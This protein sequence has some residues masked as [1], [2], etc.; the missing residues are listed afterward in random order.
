VSYS[1]F[2]KGES[3]ESDFPYRLIMIDF[4]ILNEDWSEFN[5]L[6]VQSLKQDVVKLDSVAFDKGYDNTVLVSKMNDIVK[7]E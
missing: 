4:D 1:N 7:A 2:V 6:I 3:E 5:K